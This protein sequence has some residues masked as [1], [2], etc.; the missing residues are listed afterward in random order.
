MAAF[1]QT[2][3]AQEAAD[4]CAAACQ[5]DA[6]VCPIKA[7]GNVG[8]SAVKQI[9]SQKSVAGVQ[10]LLKSWNYEAVLSGGNNGVFKFGNA[11]YNGNW[12]FFPGEAWAGIDYS[13]VPGKGV[14]SIKWM[15]SSK[16]CYEKA[17]KD[18]GSS[19]EWVTEKARSIAN[20]Y[21]SDFRLGTNAFVSIISYTTGIYTIMY[22]V[23][24]KL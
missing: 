21:Q 8:L 24:A 3:F 17:L 12:A 2:I 1:V 11:E 7:G 15:F 9:I 10:D 19:P 18:F 13:F 23:Y 22:Q 14:I 4:T 6:T 20:G 16:E 5:T